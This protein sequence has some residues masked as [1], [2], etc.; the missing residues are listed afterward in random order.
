VIANAV[1]QLIATVWVFVALARRHGYRF[2]A[3]DLTKIATAAALAFLAAKQAGT[4]LDQLVLGAVAGAIVFGVVC[5]LGRVVGRGE[6]SAILARLRTSA[7]PPAGAATEGTR[8][9]ATRQDA[10]LSRE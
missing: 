3:A 9:I 4:G 2:P 6:W 7:A 5:R 8:A 10:G 1:G